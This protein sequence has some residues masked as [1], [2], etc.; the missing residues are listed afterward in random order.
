MNIEY[1]IL[2]CYIRLCNT[3]PDR[4]DVVVVWC[5]QFS[6][7]FVCKW[8]IEIGLYIIRCGWSKDLNL[9]FAFCKLW[10]VVID[11]DAVCM[12]NMVINYT[13]VAIL[14]FDLSVLNLVILYIPLCGFCVLLN[15]IRRLGFIKFGPWHA[16]TRINMWGVQ[17]EK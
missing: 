9:A 4:I 7:M 17:N 1:I 12:C 6:S 11:K 2:I 10:C 14:I 15:F 16:C 3:F 8:S 5:L 13:L